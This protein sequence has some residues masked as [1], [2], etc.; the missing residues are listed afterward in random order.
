MAPRVYASAR[1]R[2]LDAAERLLVSEG[3]AG[4]S[5]ESVATAAGV[6]KGGFFHHF[7]TKDAMLLAMLDRLIETV[8]GQITARAADDPEP[9]GARLRAHIALSIDGSPEP[10][11][12]RGLMTALLQAVASQPAMRRR[13]HELN[14]AAVARDVGEDIPEGRAM[15]VQLALDG[16][17]VAQDMG[18]KLTARQRLALRDTL[19]ALA[20][21]EASSRRRRQAAP[22]PP[23]GRRT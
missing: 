8:E 12:P 16:L 20:R 13:A 6:S 9:R 14:V 18:V 7:K 5:V 23:K 19:M 10:V 15:L 11:V 17:G 4:L 1:D 3:L 22:A 2:I 21:P